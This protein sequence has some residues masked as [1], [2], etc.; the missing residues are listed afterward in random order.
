[1]I[2]RVSIENFMR[3]EA[4][5]NIPMGPLTLLVGQNGSGKSSVLKAIHWASRCASLAQNGKLPVE[6]MDFVPSVDFRS[7]AHRSTLQGRARGGASTMPVVVSFKRNVD[8]GTIKLK[9]LG[10]DA[11]V[12]VEAEGAVATDLVK[13]EPQTAYIPGLAGLSEHETILAAPVFRRRAASGDGGS[14]L[15]QMLLATHSEDMNTDEQDVELTE[16]SELVEKVIP[17]VRFWVKFDQRRDAFIRAWFYTPDMKYE[18]AGSNFT[19]MRRPLEMAGTGLL[20]VTQI[21]AYLLVFRPRLLLIDEP[22]AHLHQSSQERLVSALEAALKRFP[23]TQII[24]STHSPRIVRVAGQATKV[25]WLENGAVKDQGVDV[26]ARMGWGALDKDI[27]LFSEDD[28][29]EYLQSIIDQWPHLAHRTA[30]WPC[31]GVS[32]IPDGDRLAKLRERHGVKIMVH[33]DRDFMSDVDTDGWKANRNYTANN[34]PVWFSPGSD[35]ESCFQFAEH[36]SRAMEIDQAVAEK[37]LEY[38][39][40]ELDQ[41]EISASFNEAY[42]K[43]VQSLPG[44]ANAIQRWNDLGGYCQSTIK[45]KTF[46]QALRRG[47]QNAVPEFGQARKLGNMA[48]IY[49]GNST[50]PICEDLRALLQELIDG[51]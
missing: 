4:C 8:V 47:L 50:N 30:I 1:M 29:T 33:R 51:Q 46:K 31:F 45:G 16:L 13:E 6:L 38:A 49:E 40:N 18:G 43:A 3:L 44:Q 21:F 48:M 20:Q 35:I 32:S 19:T 15:R 11:G 41:D 34:I 22:D 37:G 39:L 26:R 12:N 24:V 2:D 23:D 28:N 25:V 7:L 9:A 14:V 36:I 42:N 5:Q 10:N 17:G 27:V